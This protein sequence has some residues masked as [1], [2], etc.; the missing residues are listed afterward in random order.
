MSV[1]YV[2]YGSVR[3]SRKWRRVLRAADRA[4][5]KFHVTSGHRTMAEQQA[6]FN[7]NMMRLAN[8]RWVPKPGRPLTAWPSP[9]APHIRTGSPA[10]AIDVNSLDG[11]EQR[12]ENWLD[13]RGAD[14]RNTVAGEAWHLEVSKSHLEALALS[15]RLAVPW[16]TQ[17]MSRKGREFLIR[18]EGVVPYAYNDPAGHATFG[19]GHLIHLGR[20]TLADAENWGTKIRPSSMRRVNRVLRRDLKKYEAAVRLAVGRRLPQHKFDALVSLA[21]NIG[22]GAFLWSTVAQRVRVKAGNAKVAEGIRMWNQP[23]MLK[24]RR[25]REV[26][27]Y[28]TGQYGR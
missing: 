3:V 26:L 13:A 9:T 17:R 10:H 21:F 15:L 22:I 2:P 8:G 20:V 11:G 14:A 24:P 18:E 16:A 4:G 23:A 6:L 28:R 1:S 27:L 12:L 19:V 7:Q 5:V 25:E